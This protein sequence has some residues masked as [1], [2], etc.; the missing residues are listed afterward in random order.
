[1]DAPLPWLRRLWE[2]TAYRCSQQRWFRRLAIDQLRSM[3]AACLANDAEDTFLSFFFPLKFL[4]AATLKSIQSGYVSFPLTLTLIYTH[5][6][7][8]YMLD[9][10][11]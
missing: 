5:I 2:D 9:T 3:H 4:D 1:M 8:C 6:Y 11:L 7:V 10:L